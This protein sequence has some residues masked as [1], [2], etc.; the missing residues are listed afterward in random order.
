MI[1][2]ISYL[3]E[4][5]TPEAWAEIFD[6]ASNEWYVCPKPEDFPSV[7]ELLELLPL[8]YEV[9]EAADCLRGAD[10]RPCALEYAEDKERWRWC[11][12]CLAKT[13]LSD[14]CAQHLP[15]P[16]ESP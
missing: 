8:M 15:K 4:N 3:I 14:Y 6:A 12:V 2:S 10:L 7:Q 13:E 9:V 1:S 16:E 11:D 5:G